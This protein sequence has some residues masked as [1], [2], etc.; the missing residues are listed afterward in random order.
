MTIQRRFSGYSPSHDKTTEPKE[1]RESR[2]ATKAIFPP[3]GGN[4][5]LPREMTEEA[6]R[7]IR[8]RQLMGS[9]LESPV[10]DYSPLPDPD[11]T[12]QNPRGDQGNAV[13][14]RTVFP[15]VRGPQPR[16]NM[17][18]LNGDPDLRLASSEEP[19]DLIAA[20]TI[21]DKQLLNFDN[22][23]NDTHNSLRSLRQA[24]E[25]MISSLA[26]QGNP[27]ALENA[28]SI[29]DLI[30]KVLE[31]WF[32]QLDDYLQ[33]IVDSTTESSQLGVPNAPK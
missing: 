10:M 31:P 19:T 11:L 9:E 32:L 7:A 17:R 26:T 13:D 30:T 20:V 14:G 27:T 6:R 23:M 28:K 25:G 15:M 8:A 5:A 22:Q 18:V 16:E 12:V 33:M 24:A 3:E 4:I 21:H 2:K 29:Q 1:K